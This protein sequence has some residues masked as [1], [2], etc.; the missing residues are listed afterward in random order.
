MKIRETW[1]EER[2]EKKKALGAQEMNIRVYHTK[3]SCTA[4]LIG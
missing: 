2:S 3:G 4:K 1:K